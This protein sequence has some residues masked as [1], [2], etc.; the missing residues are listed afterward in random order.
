MQSTLSDLGQWCP[1]G[2]RVIA[3]VSFCLLHK[4]QKMPGLCLFEL[5]HSISQHKSITAEA[6]GRV[7]SVRLDKYPSLL[8]LYVTLRLPICAGLLP[9]YKETLIKGEKIIHQCVSASFCVTQANKDAIVCLFNY[10]N[11]LRL[12]CI[13]QRTC[14]CWERIICETHAKL[15]I[16]KINTGLHNDHYFVLITRRRAR[17]R[18]RPYL[19]RQ[20]RRRTIN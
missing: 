9:H 5:N 12:C 8:Q 1:K 11:N 20:I 15:Y 4:Y 13:C 17:E 2:A 14:Q 10:V 6:W 19:M 7:V 16:V 18:A 3:F